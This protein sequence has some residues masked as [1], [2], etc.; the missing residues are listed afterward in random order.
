MVFRK[1]IFNVLVDVRREI[2]GT[3][4]RFSSYQ[5]TIILIIASNTDAVLAMQRNAPTH[6]ELQLTQQT[7]KG[8]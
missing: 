3:V 1:I 5:T 2:V 6:F 4:I 7:V 8:T